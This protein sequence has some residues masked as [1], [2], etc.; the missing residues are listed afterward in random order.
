MMRH[1]ALVGVLLVAAASG[2][3]DDDEPDPGARDA[4]APGPDARS[5]AGRPDGSLDAGD[6]GLDAGPPEVGEVGLDE[7]PSN[8]TCVA[9]DRPAESE[10]ALTTVEPYP[11][12]P[13]LTRPLMARP[14]PPGA[15]GG[16]YVIEQPGRLMRFDDRPDVDAVDVVIDLRGQV[17][18]NGNEEGL[19]GF[20]F[21]PDF[22]TDGR[23]F[24]SYTGF[25]GGAARSFV[26]SFRSTDGG[27]TFDPASEEVLLSIDKP[28]ANHNG[29]HIEFGPDGDL[30][31]A[32][33]DGGSG[34]DPLGNGQNVFT[35][36]GAIL[37]ID[38]DGD[39]PYEV[40]AD[41]PFVGRDGRDEI[42]AYGLR[43][44][45][46]FSFD[47]VTGDL[48]AGDV[49]QNRWEEINRI[50]RGG[51]Y[52]WNEREG[53][54]CFRADC[55]REGLVDP[56]HAYPR[57]EGRSV[58]GG[59][60]Y[61]GT[62]LPELEGV[63]VYA[64]FVTGRVWGLRPDAES[65]GWTN[66][67]L[68]TS[69]SVASFSVD[70]DRELYILQLSGNILKLV[71][72]GDPPTPGG[73]P[74][75]LSQTG[76]FDPDDPTRPAGGLVPYRP[77]ATLWS[78]GTSKERFAAL[79]DGE[80]A[81]FD[82]DGD[83]EF[84]VGTVLTKTFLRGALR[85]ETRLFVRHDDGRWAGY[86]YAWNPE[87]TDA[88]L[89]EQQAVVDFV[90]PPWRIPSRAQCL[91]C[92]TEAAG[93]SLGLEAAQLTG[94]LTYSSTGRTAEQLST[95]LA[96]DLAAP[97]AP[98]VPA[99]PAYEDASIPVEHRARAYL[100][101]NCANCHQPEGPGRGDLDLRFATPLAEMGV[102][103]VEPRHGDLGLDEARV[104]APGAPERSVL[105]SRMDRR[106][107]FGMPPLATEE[108]DAEGLTLVQGWI[109]GLTGC[110][111]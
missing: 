40:P 36:L 3:G 59:Y 11:D 53:F 6:P 33:G 103:D 12:L 96:V 85:V 109:E 4:A 60:V 7:R 93:F 14:S 75:R 86:S 44:P 28:F 105:L 5:D 48:W 31:V 2:C 73:F 79:P 29:G 84:P 63:Y 102:C 46:R 47:A 25:D 27:Q 55:Q 1:L 68:L 108:V 72:D 41:N 20:A 13:S 91:Q 74:R 45:W 110:P 94:P 21:H 82:E 30:Y 54:E 15:A 81:T 58:T 70:E 39:A 90:Q 10:I 107:V 87:Q 104:V 17:D 66:E 22:A 24:L 80:V 97:P 18:S 50:E 9:P 83:L 98:P 99:L 101:V 8:P 16:W 111:N 42:F 89:V 52:G 92:H 88:T 100:H 32:T 38:V 43:N 95:W 106:D 78:D 71:R 65:G 77:S 26:S 61:R 34:G 19:L 35:L 62:E 49:G 57:S 23:L 67:L 56:V 64:D 37:R 69:S 76:C 51:N